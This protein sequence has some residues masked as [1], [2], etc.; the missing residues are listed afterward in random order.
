MQVYCNV[1]QSVNLIAG[2][3]KDLEHRI[4]MTLQNLVNRFDTARYDVPS[5]SLEPEKSMNYEFGIKY[6]DENIRVNLFS[7]LAEYVNLITRKA[8]PVR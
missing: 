7:Y 5:L 3:Q 4:Q 2:F 6:R 1:A 8:L